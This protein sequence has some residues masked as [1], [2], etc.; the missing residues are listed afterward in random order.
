MR[1]LISRDVIRPIYD[2]TFVPAAQ[3]LYG[4]DELVMGLEINGQA[5]AYAV[6]F[7]S[8]REMVNDE[9]GGVPILVTW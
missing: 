1:Q 6:G 2:P 5:K 8:F 9:L 7:L 3:A 4:D